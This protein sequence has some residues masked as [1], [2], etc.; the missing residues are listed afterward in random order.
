MTL[1]SVRSE[2]PD[3]EVARMLGYPFGRPMEGE[4]RDLAHWARDWCRDHTRPTI[5]RRWL[6]IDRLG[7]S[8]IEWSGGVFRSRVLADRL[9]AGRAHALVALALS[10]GGGLEREVERRTTRGE[11]V[12][13]TF[14]DRFGAALAEWMAHG[15]E[16]DL[17]AERAEVGETLLAPL[18]PGHEDWTL[19]DQGALFAAFGDEPGDLELLDSGM[20]R[21]RNALLTVFGVTRFGPQVGPRTERCSRCTWSPCHFR[22]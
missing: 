21:P 18:S 13:A 9:R 11:R 6:E 8:E 15:A 3:S 10:T 5:V 7:A 4:V 17:R 22:R 16:H 2:V 20:L 1:A 14:L 19:A 12:E